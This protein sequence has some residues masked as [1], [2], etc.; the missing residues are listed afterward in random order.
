[1]KKSAEA[2]HSV[3]AWLLADANMPRWLTA[4][5]G[6]A[7][8]GA[9]WTVAVQLREQKRQSIRSNQ[10]AA[11]VVVG[12]YLH[13]FHA[14]R[15]DDLSYADVH[16]ELVGNAEHF[17]PATSADRR[18]YMEYASWLTHISHVSEDLL[19]TQALV[20]MLGSHVNALVSNAYVQDQLLAAPANY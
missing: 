6:L 12:N 10:L 15:G 7:G 9:W 18:V 1:M 3:R 2:A 16:K 5:F 20:E 13:E 11:T 19:P 14:K 17:I 8:L 4:L